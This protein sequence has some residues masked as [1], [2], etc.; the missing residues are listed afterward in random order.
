M[1]IELM[2][3]VMARDEATDPGELGGGVP[4]EM[5]LSGAHGEVMCTLAW[6]CRLSVA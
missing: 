2:K 3:P 5:H 6:T 4:T 1:F